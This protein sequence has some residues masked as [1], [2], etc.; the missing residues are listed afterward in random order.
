MA[1]ALKRRLG[2]GLLT[3]YGV[4]VIVG[5]GIYVLIGTVVGD[6]G[7][8][9]PLAFLLAGLVALPSA[10][11]FAEFST[12][13]PEAAGAAAFVAAGFGSRKFGTAVGLAMVAAAVVS[14]A[15]VL[16]GG[17]GYLTALVPVREPWLI[18]ALGAA[19]V[20][21]AIAGVVESMAFAAALT[22]VE[23]AGLLLVVWAGL[24]AAPVAAWQ[25]PPAADWAGIGAAVSLC[26]FAF[27]GFDNIA[28]MAEET[29]DPARVLPRAILISLAITATLY[30]LVALAA[31]RAVEQAD[32]A[33]SS[34]PLA[35][36]W[37]RATGRGG[38]FLSAIAVAAAANGVL[39]QVVMAARVL[40]GL[41]RR[42]AWLARMHR[43]HPRFG[44]PV[45]ATL[46]VGAALTAAALAVPVAALAEVTSAVLLVVFA[47]VN[48]ALI[49]IKARQPDATFRV[50]VL[51]P[52]AG[53][54]SA[55][56]ALAALGWSVA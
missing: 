45:E 17:A 22:A 55:L 33:V 12:R 6:A 46:L 24:S 50:P 21:V 10:L 54:A 9:A 34:Q 42:S 30:V 49:R 53:L 40:Y 7:V 26:F 14:G 39:A 20:L 23:V 32:I 37:E 13:M 31:V 5:A 36:L 3:A 8:W 41:G 43:A 47:L 4:G 16:R 48:L 51:V 29:R 27:I 28:N 52:V 35:L 56:M 19:L 44:T 18:V 2:P 38:A 25:T 1:G 11:A 15:A